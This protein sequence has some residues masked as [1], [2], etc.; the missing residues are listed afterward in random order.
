M[1][2]PTFDAIVVA[3][4]VGFLVPV[5]ASFVPIQVALGEKIIEA[6]NPIRNKTVAIKHETYI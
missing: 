4:V 3:A 2:T 5:V 6:I 1:L